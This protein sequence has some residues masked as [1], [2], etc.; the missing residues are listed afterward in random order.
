MKFLIGFS[1]VWFLF[2]T[3]EPPK[4]ANSRTTPEIITAD[5]F[6]G[7]SVDKLA[8]QCVTLETELGAIEMAMM[9]EV[10]PEA[11]RNFL[12]LAATGSLDSNQRK[13]ER[14]TRKTHDAQV[15]RRDRNRQTRPRHRFNG[16]HG[17]A[18]QRDHPLL[19]TRQ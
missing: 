6:D 12:N 18:K 15:A 10:A 19:H 16:P 7:A 9:P 13:V 5:P 1:L 14:R 8:S 3:Q 11:V 2:F 17:R 4:K